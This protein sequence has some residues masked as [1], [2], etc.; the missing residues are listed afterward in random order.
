MAKVLTTASQ[1]TCK[2]LPIT[3]SSSAVLKVGGNPVLL[4]ADFDSA[5]FKCT[6]V[7]AA[8]GPCKK[9]APFTAGISTVLK[10][11]GKPVVLADAKALTDATAANGGEFTVV[12]PGQT[13]L[14]AK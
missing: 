7:T 11:G 10:V 4:K 2:H 8:G 14:D 5:T 6:T 13:I 1:L 12:D 9:L 3:V